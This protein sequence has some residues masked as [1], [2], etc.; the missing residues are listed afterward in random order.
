MKEIRTEIDENKK[1]QSKLTVENLII[2]ASNSVQERMKKI[3]LE[4]SERANNLRSL[5][6]LDLNEDSKP[7]LSPESKLEKEL[8]MA[9]ESVHIQTYNEIK[10][11]KPA[12]IR[13]LV[14]KIRNL[15]HDEVRFALNPI[16]DR[17]TQFNIHTIKTL[18][19]MIKKQ[20][21]LEILR[22]YNEL[23]K[24]EPTRNELDTWIKEIDLVR[25]RQKI[26]ESAEYRNVQE[27]QNYQDLLLFKKFKDR[28]EYYEA[29][30]TE[31]KNDN[32]HALS[33]VD[34]QKIIKNT[35]PFIER[36]IEYLWVLR[37]L[38]TKGNL[39][40]VGCLDSEFANELTKIKSLSVY[41]VD[42]RSTAEKP[43][44]Q[45]YQ[46]DACNL[47]FN[48]N[49]FDMITIISSVEHFGMNIYGAEKRDDADKAAIME[50]RRVLKPTG[51]LFLTIPFGKYSKSWS[52]VYNIKT[53]KVLL[54]DFNIL[55][56]KYFEQKD[57]G[58]LE[59]TKEIAETNEG[60]KFRKYE[61]SSGAI[62]CILAKKK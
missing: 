19:E 28:K 24:R 1:N 17:Q 57:F 30:E 61:E 3:L 46:D 50:L 44:F 43:L 51:L 14:L 33:F 27:E 32:P 62:A 40:D 5:Q 42:I 53:L 21:E 4:D 34:F 13:R 35:N 25:L 9:N 23:L 12:F 56:E 38:P 10:T 39:L 49:Y 31:R 11:S 26:K 2:F 60:S 6:S 52:R 7:S 22:A 47:S 8:R 41:G 59:T 15:L 54:E 18:N 37:N 58:W 20:N 16:V 36:N 48:D 55:E 29:F 45:F